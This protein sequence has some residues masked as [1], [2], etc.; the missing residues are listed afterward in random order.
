MLSSL[1][2]YFMSILN[3][4]DGRLWVK[5]LSTL[6]KALLYKWSWRFANEKEAFWNQVIKGKYGK[7]RGGWCS[8]EGG[9]SWS[10]LF[11]RPFND[12][13]L[14]EVESLLLCLHGKRLHRDEE[15]KVLW[16]ETKSGKFSLKSLYKALELGSLVYFPMKIIWNLWVQPKVSFFAW[17]ATWGKL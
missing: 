10:P 9:G 7:E 2:I 4:K 3:A 6:N 5:C 14:D 12:W 1:P 13:K 15:D 16:T 8:Q 17:E 11:S